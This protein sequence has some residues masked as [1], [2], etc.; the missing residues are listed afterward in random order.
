MTNQADDH[1]DG[2][3][4]DSHLTY[5][6]LDIL[7]PIRV[8]RESIQAGKVEEDSLEMR[9]AQFIGISDVGKGKSG[10]QAERRATQFVVDCLLGRHPDKELEMWSLVREQAELHNISMY[11][12]EFEIISRLDIDTA[13]FFF[14]CLLISLDDEVSLVSIIFTINNG[15]TKVKIYRGHAASE[16]ISLVNV[17]TGGVTFYRNEITVPLVPDT[18]ANCMSGKRVD[19]VISSTYFDNLDITIRD[20]TQK[21]SESSVKIDHN[22]GIEHL[23]RIAESQIEQLRWP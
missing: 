7:A 12:A 9:V 15:N 13:G 10:V 16:M 4:K 6:N 21:S 14:L 11:P 23:H 2:T 8:L 18:L 22:Q 19:E 5:D 17:T 3:T 1:L 20:V